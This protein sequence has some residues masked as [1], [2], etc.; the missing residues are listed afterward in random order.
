MILRLAL[1]SVQQAIVA[2]KVCIIIVAC[3]VCIIIVACKVCIIACKPV[4]M[5][6]LSSILVWVA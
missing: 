1:Q 3:K 6:G 4:I 2:C 5:A